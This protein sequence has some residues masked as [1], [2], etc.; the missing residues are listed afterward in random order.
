MR[1]PLDH[2][3]VSEDFRLVE[4]EWEMMWNQ[5]IFRCM[6]SLA[7]SQQKAKNQERPSLLKKK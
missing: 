5:I 2:L 6:Q 3:F 7:W 1:W 4:M